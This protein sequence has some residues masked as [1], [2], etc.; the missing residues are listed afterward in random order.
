MPHMRLKS[1]VKSTTQMRIT[2]YFKPTREM[3]EKMAFSP[4][5][6]DMI[7]QPSRREMRAHKAFKCVTNSTAQ[8][9]VSGSPLVHVKNASE[10]MPLSPHIL[11]PSLYCRTK[12]PSSHCVA[13]L[14]RPHCRCLAVATRAWH[15]LKKVGNCYGFPMGIGEA[16]TC[17]TLTQLGLAPILSLSPHTYSQLRAS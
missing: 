5:K 11:S 7:S 2:S 8:R 4:P 3:P 14:V 1:T 16:C 13:C 10:K 17:G 6:C 9:Y 15:F 12:K